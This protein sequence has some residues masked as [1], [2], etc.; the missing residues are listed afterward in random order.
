MMDEDEFLQMG[1]PFFSVSDRDCA[2]V[3]TSP[4]T[5]FM[6]APA[7]FWEMFCPDVLQ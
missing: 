2:V 3:G 5:E 1:T 7:I 6:Y 4:D